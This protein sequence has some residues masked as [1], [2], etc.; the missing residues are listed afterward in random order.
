MSAPSLSQ[1]QREWLGDVRPRLDGSLAKTRHGHTH[2]HTHAHTQETH[3]V[4]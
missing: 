1:N 2:T 3:T 4:L